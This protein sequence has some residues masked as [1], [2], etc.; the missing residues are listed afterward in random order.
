MLGSMLGV[1][2]LALAVAGVIGW[3]VAVANSAP[4]LDQLKPRVPGQVSEVFA[5]DGSP[6]GYI[7]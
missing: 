4:N 3:V 6:L 7:A 2:A 1:V 5:A